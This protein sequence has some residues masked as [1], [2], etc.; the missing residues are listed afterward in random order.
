M[1]TGLLR[2]HPAGAGRRAQRGHSLLEITIAMGVSGLLALAGVT[3][4]DLGHTE[5]TAA[6]HEL[7]AS[8]DQAFVLARARGVNITVGLGTG[9]DANHLPIRLGRRVKWGKPP[10][11]PLPPGMADPVKADATGEAHPTITVT[12]RH[13]ATASLWFLNDGEDALCMRLSNRGRIQLLRWRAA[14]RRWAKA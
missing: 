8:L 1:G 13:T 2:R 3:R 12:P 6:Q 4:L 5:L 14:T 10:R 9:K 11:V 7:T